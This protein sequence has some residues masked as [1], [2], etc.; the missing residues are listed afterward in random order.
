M[1]NFNPNKLENMMMNIV[2]E[3]ERETWEEIEKEKDALKRCELR[4][5][6]SKAIKKIRSSN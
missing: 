1:Q 4:M 2:S 5:L 6:Y 3:G